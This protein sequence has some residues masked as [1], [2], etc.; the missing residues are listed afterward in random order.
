MAEIRTRIWMA[1]AQA[2]HARIPLRI[3]LDLRSD[4]LRLL[5]WEL[6]EAADNKLL[7]KNIQWLR[8]GNASSLNSSGPM[9]RRT[10]LE[11]MI[12]VA[13]PNDKLLE[14]SRLVCGRPCKGCGGP[15]S[16]GWGRADFRLHYQGASVSYTLFVAR[17]LPSPSNWSMR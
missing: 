2:D 3:L 10:Q 17:E 5:P 11:V 6:I 14:G 1:K 4:V 13:D 9:L 15:R 16:C 12:H 8:V 7:P